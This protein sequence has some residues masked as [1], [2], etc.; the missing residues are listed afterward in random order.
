MSGVA[1]SPDIQAITNDDVLRMG[2]VPLDLPVAY[3][4]PCT[5]GPGLCSLVLTDFLSCQQ[6]KLLEF[7]SKQ[8]KLKFS[9]LEHDFSIVNITCNSVHVHF[10]ET[11]GIPHTT[12]PT[13][14]ALA[15]IICTSFFILYTDSAERQCPWSRFSPFI[16]SPMRG[17]L[18]RSS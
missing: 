15:N 11:G 1:S 12:S 14:L 10:C 5:S 18:T 2:D 7:C 4:L 13:L 17:R 9:G 8:K 3:L 6:N 16:W